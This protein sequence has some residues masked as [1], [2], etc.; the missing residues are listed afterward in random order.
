MSYSF[1]V[2]ANTKTDVNQQIRE[3]FDAV[4]VSQ[5]NHAADKEA[6]VVAAQAFVELMTEPHAGQE[7]N[8]AMHGS[9]S[10]RNDNPHQFLDA[11]V[12]ISVSLRD[13]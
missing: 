12:S 7:I 11:S 1:S 4:V 10:W 2:T 9:L 5:P 8:V 3:Q 13:K 6:A